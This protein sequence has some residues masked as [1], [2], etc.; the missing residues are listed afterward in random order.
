MIL[1]DEEHQRAIQNF[2]Q[3]RDILDDNI[4][5]QLMSSKWIRVTST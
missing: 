1:L 4:I 5:Q 3:V 2:E